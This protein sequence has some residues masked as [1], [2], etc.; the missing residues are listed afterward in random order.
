MGEW[1]SGRSQSREYDILRG[2]KSG[3]YLES[4]WRVANLEAVD[5]YVHC[6][7]DGANVEKDAQ[8]GGV[9]R[10]LDDATV[11][12]RRIVVG[13]R[14][15]ALVCNP[16]RLVLE[17]VV[18]V[19]IYGE[20]VSRELLRERERRERERRERERKRRY[21]RE[22]GEAS[23]AVGGA[24]ALLAAPPHCWRRL[25]TGVGT[26]HTPT[27]RHAT[28]GRR[29]GREGGERGAKKKSGRTQLAGTSM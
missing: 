5:P 16:R 7:G 17:D 24:S 29:K 22:S 26:R 9:P 3:E 10:H 2:V 6:R 11:G 23:R 14:A 19:G 1:G 12:A 21:T 15:L 25:H 18:H 27:W 4:I 20:A 13:S 8:L 28:I